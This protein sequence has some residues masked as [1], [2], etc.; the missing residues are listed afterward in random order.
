MCVDELT[1]QECQ[2]FKHLCDTKATPY[3][4]LKCC[5]TCSLYLNRT[6]NEWSD[7]LASRRKATANWGGHVLRLKA[8]LRRE[9]SGSQFVTASVCS[10]SYVCRLTVKLKTTTAMS[11]NGSRPKWSQKTGHT[12]GSGCM[13]LS[14]WTSSEEIAG[15]EPELG[16]LMAWSGTHAT[17]QHYMTV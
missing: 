4:R 16:R 3:F 9:S 2:N 17:R 5:H 12:L 7:W 15:P 10:G 6:F 11:R 1:Y 8:R 14:L 13:D